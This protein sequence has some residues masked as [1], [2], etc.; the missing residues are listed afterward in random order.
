MA[1][2]ATGRSA[3]SLPSGGG[4]GPPGAPGGAGDEPAGSPDPSAPAAGRSAGDGFGASA[5]AACFTQDGGDT[6]VA[7]IVTTGFMTALPLLI[8]GSVGWALRRRFLRLRAEAER[9]APGAVV[10]GGSAD[11]PAA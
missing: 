9:S 2:P 3:P 6:R 5:C 10:T 4:G 8:L 11:R 1:A 7:F